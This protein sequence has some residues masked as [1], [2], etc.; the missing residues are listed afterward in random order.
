MPYTGAGEK[1]LDIFKK[2]RDISVSDA[3]V[4][5]KLGL[6]L[7][8][9]KYYEEGLYAFKQAEQLSEGS[10]LYI[11]ASLVW[12]GHITDL[13]GRRDKAVAFYKKALQ[14]DPGDWIR[15]DQYRIKIDRQWVEE[16]LKKPFERK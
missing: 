16:R 15:H 4:W 6:A 14:K 2:V 12:Q 10:P 1:S 7:Y 11:F 3:G 9:G 13:L 5:F 8:D